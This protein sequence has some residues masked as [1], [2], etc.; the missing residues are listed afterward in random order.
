M[1]RRAR[2]FPG[3]VNCTAIDYFHEWPRTA[4]ESVSKKFLLNLE[5]LPVRDTYFLITKNAQI[6]NSIFFLNYQDDLTESVA[7]FMAYVLSSVNELSQ[8]Y[9]TNEKRYN[10]TTPKSFLE[11]IALYSK[12]LSDKTKDNLERISRLE[13]GLVRL[14][15]C[16]E[17]V[18][19]LKVYFVFVI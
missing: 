6:F 19:S 16:A 8:T 17:Q 13:N 14:A 18:H 10:Y 15:Q 2:K 7:K 1:R 5:Y 12:L 3:L 9:L 11:L 4:L